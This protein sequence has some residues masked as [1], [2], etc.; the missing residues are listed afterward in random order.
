MHRPLPRNTVHCFD[1]TADAATAAL[2]TRMV[3]GEPCHPDTAPGQTGSRVPVVDSLHLPHWTWKMAWETTETTFFVQCFT[4]AWLVI[5]TQ[6]GRISSVLVANETDAADDPVRILLGNRLDATATLLVRQLVA[7]AE[8]P[9]PRL[10][11]MVG[12]RPET[13]SQFQ[14]IRFLMRQLED[15]VWRR[16]AA[17]AVAESGAGPGRSAPQSAAA[18][19][20]TLD[21][22]VSSPTRANSARIWRDTS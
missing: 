5:I 18:A 11:L 19:E 14:F 10:V 9:R 8:P 4:D 7:R 1:S 22:T 2:R 16:A 3:Q 20:A 21:H 12:L 15:R 17:S 13:S 6:T